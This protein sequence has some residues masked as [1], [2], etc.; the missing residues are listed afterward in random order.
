MSD[1]DNSKKQESVAVFDSAVFRAATKFFEKV[2][3]AAACT[4]SVEVSLL[5]YVD[6]LTGSLRIS[7]SY[8]KKLI[9]LRMASGLGCAGLFSFFKRRR[10]Y[11]NLL[12]S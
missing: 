7:H 5:Y 1:L 3:T 10:K 4:M 6:R 8:E 11:Q 9:G 2:V 12:F